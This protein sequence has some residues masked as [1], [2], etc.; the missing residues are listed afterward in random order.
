MSYSVFIE[1]IQ[2]NSKYICDFDQL[3]IKSQKLSISHYDAQFITIICF[4]VKRTF[5][6]NFG[7]WLYLS[8][9]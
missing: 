1:F 4:L 3:K 2:E 5:I 8:M 9:T 7:F 6:N